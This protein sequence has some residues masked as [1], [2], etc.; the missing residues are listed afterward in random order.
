MADVKAFLKEQGLTDDEIGAMSPKQQGVFAT[1]LGKF[2]EGTA[3][4]TKSAAEMKKAQAE[5]GEAEKFWNDKITPALANVDRKVATA[6]ANSARRGAYLKSLKDQGYDVP[7]EMIADSVTRTTDPGRDPGTGKYVTPEEMGKEFRSVAPT[8]VSLVSLSNEYQDLYGT[9]YISAE[10]D[11][12]ESRLA[13]KSLRDFVRE[14]YDFAGKK[15]AREAKKTDD[16]VNQKADE[17]YKAREAELVAKYGDNPELRAPVSSRFD[18]IA[19]SL[20]DKKDAW[21][22]DAG[23]KDARSARLA[24]FENVQVQ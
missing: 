1:A 8:M 21:K 9:P 2:D 22:T 17:K 12:E 24:K 5:Y 13:R 14:K 15:A 19:K 3:A 23:R 6:E 16:L 11:F 10:A 20:G 18:K 4:L 7:D